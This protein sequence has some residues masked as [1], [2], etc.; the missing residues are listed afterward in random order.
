MLVLCME[1]RIVLEI[2]QD[3]RKFLRTK[4]QDI[5]QLDKDGRMKDFFDRQEDNSMMAEGRRT[6][7]I[8]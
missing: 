7:T 4:G 2:S 8:V 3:K 5:G 6:S 1:E